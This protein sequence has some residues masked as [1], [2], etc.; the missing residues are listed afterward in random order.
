VDEVLAALAP[1]GATVPVTLRLEAEALLASLQNPLAGHLP[2]AGWTAQPL[3]GPPR[4]VVPPGVHTIAV[5]AC[6]TAERVSPPAVLA[7]HLLP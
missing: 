7:A 3:A 4:I 5:V 1:R 2:P 6:D